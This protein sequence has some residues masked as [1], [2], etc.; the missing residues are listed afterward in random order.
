MITRKMTIMAR[1]QD[2]IRT[3]HTPASNLNFN[4][5]YENPPETWNNRAIV[6]RVIVILLRPGTVIV[7]DP[8]IKLIIPGKSL[9]GPGES[10]REH[11][12]LSVRATII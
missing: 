1:L 5:L 4:W 7:D 6:T 2:N 9:H 12:R 11:D 10:C 8:S 3:Y